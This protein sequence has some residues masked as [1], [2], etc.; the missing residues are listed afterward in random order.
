MCLLNLVNHYSEQIIDYKIRLMEIYLSL[1]G[2]ISNRIMCCDHQTGY[3]QNMAYHTS[4][5]IHATYICP[6]TWTVGSLELTSLA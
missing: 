1:I 2:S 3:S 5:T 4:C 6:G